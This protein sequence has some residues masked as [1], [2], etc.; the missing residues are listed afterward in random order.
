[1]TKTGLNGGK[2]KT[3]KKYSLSISP[4][5]DDQIP[6]PLPSP[7]RNPGGAIYTVSSSQLFLIAPKLFLYFCFC[8]FSRPL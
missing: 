3:M 2:N 4:T 7:F 6:T 5:P 1:M 8:N